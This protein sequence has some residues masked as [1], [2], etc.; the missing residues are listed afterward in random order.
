MDYLTNCVAKRIE[1]TVLELSIQ[2]YVKKATSP[3]AYGL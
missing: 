2:S 3:I 1:N